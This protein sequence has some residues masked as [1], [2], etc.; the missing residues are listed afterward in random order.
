MNDKIKNRI[1]KLKN[2]KKVINDYLNVFKNNNKA[3]ELFAN[4]YNFQ[5]LNEIKKNID[6]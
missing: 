5:K 2:D 3:K 4:N 6:E 1:I